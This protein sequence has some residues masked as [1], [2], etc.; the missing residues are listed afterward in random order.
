MKPE[1]GV[2]KD[3]KS[4]Q[5]SNTLRPVDGSKTRLLLISAA[6][7]LV[8][9][10]G[11]EGVSSRQIA[12]AAGQT[13]NYAVQYHFGSKEG[14]LDAVFA[15]RLQR[16]DAVRAELFDTVSSS[17]GEPS[18]RRWLDVLLLPLADEVTAPESRYVSF[19]ARVFLYRFN[20]IPLWFG[21]GERPI[22]PI[23][24][25]AAEMIRAQISYVPEAVRNRRMHVVLAQCL[26][27]LASFEQQLANGEAPDL[28]F[29]VF[30]T[31]L[32]DTAAQGL[33]TPLS[34]AT[35]SALRAHETR[36]ETS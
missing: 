36:L 7:K 16:V 31:D 18:V 10:N 27:A 21:G 6:E 15:H 25:R 19:L 22:S 4:M 26:L 35:A 5:D 8:A 33:A 28:P 11:P 2:A 13:N 24:I 12:A 1:T 20:E 17:G 3:S 29:D 14:L 30:V 32:L 23:A 34:E 9:E